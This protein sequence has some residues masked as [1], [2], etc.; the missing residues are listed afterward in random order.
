MSLS[1]ADFAE[2]VGKVHSPEGPEQRRPFPWQQTLLERVVTDR[3]WPAVIDVPTGLGKTSVIDVFTFASALVPDRMPRRLFFVIDRRIV[4]DEAYEHARAIENALSEPRFDVTRE[5]A[6]RVRVGEGRPLTAT[7]MR[8]GTTWSWRWVERPDQRAVVVATVDQVGSRYLFRGYGVSDRLRPIDAALVGS[9]SLI[10]V[11]EAHLSHALLTTLTKAREI[12]AL[13]ERQVAAPPLLV[14]MSATPP[15]DELADVHSISDADRADPVAARRLGA[16]KTLRTVEVSTTRSRAATLVPVVMAALAE[17]LAAESGAGSVVG[18]VANTVSRAR[19]AFEDLRSRHANVVLLTGR[20]R[21]VDRERLHAEWYDRLKAGRV[22]SADDPV[23][24]VATQTIEVGAN[25][26]LDGLVTESAPLS[27]IVQ[28]LGRLNRLGE[29]PR[30][31]IAIVVHDSTVTDDDQP[32][33]PARLRTWE[34]LVAHVPP[35]PHTDD[36]LGEGLAGSPAALRAL[37]GPTRLAEL[38]PTSEYVPVLFSRTLD[39][40]TRTAP[41]PWP[42]TP[43]APFLHGIERAVADVSIVWRHDVPE[44]MRVETDVKESWTEALRQV[45]PASDEMLDVSPRALRA[46]LSGRKAAPLADVEGDEAPD[47]EPGEPLHPYVA[48]YRAEQ[49]DVV[50]VVDVAPGD[51][52]VVPTSWGGCDE[53]GWHPASTDAVVDV[54][55]VASR[56]TRPLVRISPYLET[57]AATYGP[58]VRDV[59]SDLIRDE[60]ELGA[61]LSEVPAGEHA[62]LLAGVLRRLATEPRLTRGES[63]GDVTLLSALV[64]PDGED[65]SAFGSSAAGNPMSLRA[66]QAA[67]RDRATE[68]ATALGLSDDLV[69][70]VGKAAEWHDEGKRDPRFQAMLRGEESHRALYDEPLAKSGMSSADRRAF[71][72]ARVNAGYPARMRHEALSARAAAAWLARSAEG[73]DADLVQHL[74][75]SHHGW[76]RPLLPPVKDPDPRKVEFPDDVRL[77]TGDCVDFTQPARFARL[78]ARYGRWGLALLETIVRMADIWCSERGEAG[79]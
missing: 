27:S 14:T 48:R 4:V 55:D 59:V 44:P 24:V 31:T 13:R 51:V 21:P 54:A 68:F 6:E 74:V 11:D 20:I 58:D 79:E 8:G 77:E 25:V 72:E 60:N 16:A 7:R 78:N 73:V 47:D 50:A 17:R 38:E 30:D 18:I 56:G 28:R 69:R 41:S 37:V 33:G 70:A 49:V 62:S 3:G 15:S 22:R 32:Y 64:M 40:W 26:D 75:A 19:A 65:S 71:R 12:D 5:V 61:V 46:W 57:V 42:D 34:W 67:V 52:V 76:S 63:A 35:T 39:A 29:A 36:V 23:F 9:D 10:V 2:F 45:P 43:V 66:H 53:F 1:P